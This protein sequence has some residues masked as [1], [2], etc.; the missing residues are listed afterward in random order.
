[1]SLKS[2][3]VPT[4]AAATVYWVPVAPAIAEHDSLTQRDHECEWVALPGSQLASLPVST[5]PTAGNWP[6]LR[7]ADDVGHTEPAV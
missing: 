1:M 2:R 6:P 5:V 7:R 4:S 3:R